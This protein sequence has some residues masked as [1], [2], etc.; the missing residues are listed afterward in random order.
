MGGPDSSRTFIKCF[1]KVL[2]SS[3]ES[4]ILK[5]DKLLA[6]NGGKSGG[7]MPGIMKRWA[8]EGKKEETTWRW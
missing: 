7:K 8:R 1:I 3:A 6:E 4:G 5:P 2:T